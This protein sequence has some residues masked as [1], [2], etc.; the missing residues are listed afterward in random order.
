MVGADGQEACHLYFGPGVDLL[1]LGWLGHGPWHGHPSSRTPVQQALL[2]SIRQRGPQFRPTDLDGAPRQP[3]RGRQVLQPPSHVL[4]VETVEADRA[5]PRLDVRDRP[6]VL[7][8]R[9][10]GHVRLDTSLMLGLS[11]EAQEIVSSLVRLVG[12]GGF[13]PPTSCT[14]SRCASTAPL[15]VDRRSAYPPGPERRPEWMWPHPTAARRPVPAFGCDA[16]RRFWTV[17]GRAPTASRGGCGGA[18]T[19]GST[20]VPHRAVTLTPL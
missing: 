16:V 14:Q 9:F 12:E 5:E 15:P 20:G 10:Q 1:L 17:A 18:A 2:D 19:G 7:L 3:S 6:F 11:G 8:P 4:S 13:E